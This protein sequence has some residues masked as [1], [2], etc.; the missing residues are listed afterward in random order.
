MAG[1]HADPR[2]TLIT[3]YPYIHGYHHKVLSELQP[4]LHDGFCSRDFAFL[5]LITLEILRIMDDDIKPSNPTEWMRY[6]LSLAKQSPP[7]PSNYRVG[8]VLLEEASQEVLAT[9]YTL[10]LPGNTH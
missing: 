7:K 6:A 10:E 4:H 9:G 3:M 2:P 1:L 5:V 8:A